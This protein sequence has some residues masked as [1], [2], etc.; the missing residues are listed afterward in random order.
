LITTY[1]L[2]GRWVEQAWS[3]RLICSEKRQ[4]PLYLSRLDSVPCFPLPSDGVEA[5]SCKNNEKRSKKKNNRRGNLKM[6]VL[7]VVILASL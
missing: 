1:G 6:Q 4:R 7:S 5:Q 3:A 2:V